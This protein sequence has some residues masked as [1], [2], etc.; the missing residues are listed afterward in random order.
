[1]TH[2]SYLS[3]ILIR[4]RMFFHSRAELPEYVSFQIPVK[5]T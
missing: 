5:M 3:G 1:M 4:F 2:T